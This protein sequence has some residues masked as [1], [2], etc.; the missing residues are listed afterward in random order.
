MSLSQ[1]SL[2]TSRR[3]EVDEPPPDLA[4]FRLGVGYI[5]VFK[6]EGQQ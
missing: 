2:V 5:S 1:I 4:Q 3:M 6:T